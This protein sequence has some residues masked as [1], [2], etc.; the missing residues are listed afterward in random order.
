MR[1]S[2][3]SVTTELS[4]LKAISSANASWRSGPALYTHWES[5]VKKMPVKPFTT[6]PIA[7][8][9]ISPRPAHSKYARKRP[10][11]FR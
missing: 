6:S 3:S 11:I 2:L 4:A 9:A 1:S 10:S 7:K 8:N 5:M